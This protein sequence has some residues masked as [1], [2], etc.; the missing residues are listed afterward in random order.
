MKSGEIS[1]RFR[2]VGPSYSTLDG[3]V[4]SDYQHATEWLSQRF[5]DDEFRAEYS[6]EEVTCVGISCRNC[7]SPRLQAGRTM[8]I[9]EFL[10]KH[11]GE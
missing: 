11:G 3:Y 10:R 1:V 7:H 6:L 2:H 8:T 9:S 4:F 5:V